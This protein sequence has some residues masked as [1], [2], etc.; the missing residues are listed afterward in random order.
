M[1]IFPLILLSIS[2][3][4]ASTI[5]VVDNQT[6]AALPGVNITVVGTPEGLNTDLEGNF[7]LED[8]YEGHKFK[9]SYIGYIDTTL[10]YMDVLALSVIALNPDILNLTTVEVV[11]S[12]LEWE[13][14]DLPAIVT[15]LRTR[16]MINQGATELREVL[17]RDPSVV[18]TENNGG[19]QQISIR[20]SNANEVMIV[21]DGIP[22]NSGYGGRFDLSWLNLN[23]VESVSIVKGAGTLRYSSGAFG[24]VVV[25]EPQKVGQS[26]LLVN[27][28][29]DDK[30]LSS[31]SVSDVIQWRNLRTR[32]TY[33]SREIMP[34]GSYPGSI[35]SDRNFLNLYVG[36]AFRDTSNI[37]GVSHMDIR[38]SRSPSLNYEDSYQDQYTQIRYQGDLGVLPQMTFQFMKRENSSHFRNQNEDTFLNSSDAGETSNLAVIENKILGKALINFARLELRNDFHTSESEENNVKWDQLTFHKIDLKQT[39]FAATEIVKYRAPLHLLLV[40]FMELNASFRYDKLDLKKS[41][42]A[43]LD[44]DTY[45]DDANNKVYDYLSK[46]NGFTLNKT[47]DAL[48]YQLFYSSGTSIRYPSMYDEYLRENTTIV[49]YQS[50]HLKPELNASLEFGLQ[51]TLQPKGR[52]NIVDLVDVQISSFKNRYIDKIYYRAIPRALP[53]PVNFSATTN[54]T[55]YELSTSAALF[56]GVVNVFVGT[57]RIDIS[58]FTIFPNKPKFKDVAEVEFAVKHGNVRLQYFHEGEQYYAG[59]SDG[60]NYMVVGLPGRENLNLYASSKVPIL[61]S[62]IIFGVGVQ[63]LMSASNASYY[64]D[65]R[66]WVLNLGFKI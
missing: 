26:S 45:I 61:G 60:I 18:V 19:E 53:T 65:E 41:H 2:I 28:Q 43:S 25:I 56:Q 16:E 44:G 13:H 11:S 37:L 8:R 4:L 22:M 51:L 29:R 20:G 27:A 17:E 50:D 33:S 42:I 39:R 30:D 9:F 23:D 66:S 38:E 63:N 32:V 58:S 64:F 54:L 7:V 57:T 40:D 62:A 14:T 59:S 47:R 31:Y 5:Q 24:G 49:R 35:I 1:K 36:Y 12:K 55:G 3:S 52:F 6:G 21:Y 48:K 46:R 15:V 10:E 34:F